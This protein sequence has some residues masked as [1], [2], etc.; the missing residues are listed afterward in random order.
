[1]KAATAPQL[2]KS[3]EMADALVRSGVRFVPMPVVDDL[4]FQIRLSEMNARL[5]RIIQEVE[6][7]QK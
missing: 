1:M 7:E 2:R 5:E 6:N 3:L 4:D